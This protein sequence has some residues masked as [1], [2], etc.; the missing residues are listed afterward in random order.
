VVAN[1]QNKLKIA[2]L[3]MDRFRK[4]TQE[5]LSQANKMFDFEKS[6]KEKGLLNKRKQLEKESQA[7]IDVIKDG[8]KKDSL[9]LLKSRI[10][11][12]DSL[13]TF[14]NERQKNFDK[15]FS[16]E[17]LALQIKLDENLKQLESEK[18][19][20]L[21]QQKQ[22]EQG[23]TSTNNE[24]DIARQKQEIQEEWKKLEKEKAGLDMER[25]RIREE[26]MRLEA[27]K[28]IKNR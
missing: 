12:E 10:A 24:N 2:G 23:T 18:E 26:R 14:D 22:L 8:I 20:V 1:E 13:R 27:D 25:K 5:E 19:P 11:A 21:E 4:S 28:K 6:E 7:K 17:S 15:E 3:D 9:I 16:A